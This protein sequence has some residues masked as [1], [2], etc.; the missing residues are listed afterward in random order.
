MFLSRK[1]DNVVLYILLLITCYFVSAVA[2]F[3]NN[4]ICEYVNVDLFYRESY[5]LIQLI[6]H[7]DKS[8]KT[9]DLINRLLDNLKTVNKLITHIFPQLFLNIFNI[10]L[11]N[12]RK[13]I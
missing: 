7:S 1:M 11:P 12:L 10:L 9:G 4:Y 2:L 13:K 6:F 5:E 8:L 3:L